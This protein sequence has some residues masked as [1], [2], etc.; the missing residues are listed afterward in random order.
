[1]VYMMGGWVLGFNAVSTLM[2]IHAYSENK[3]AD[4]LMIESRS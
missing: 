2:V 4:Y 3:V 1:M